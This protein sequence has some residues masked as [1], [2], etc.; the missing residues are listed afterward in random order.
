MVQNRAPG[1]RQAL[2]PLSVEQD[3]VALSPM[4][5]WEGVAAEYETLGLSPQH[6]AMALL[7][8]ALIVAESGAKPHFS[9]GVGAE[10][11]PQS[12]LPLLSSAEVEALPDGASVRMAGLV[13]CRQRPSTAKGVVF[14]SLEDEYGLA[15]VVV[16]APLF[17]R[18][19]TLL[20]SQP[21][22]IVHGRVQRQGTVVHIIA[23][24]FERPQMQSTPLIDISRDF[25]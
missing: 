21:F 23:D 7:R 20:L 24:H 18:Q 5:A 19:R 14:V 22:M 9:G 10:P 11:P 13:T 17:E 8:P 15:N 25:H 2:L 6:Q 1:R 12:K 4:S 3:M 16:Y